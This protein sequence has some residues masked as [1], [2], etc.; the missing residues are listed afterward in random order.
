MMKADIHDVARAA[1]VSISTVSRSFTHPEMVS[2][3]TRRR[4][5][6][7]ASR[8]D[9]AISR[10][11]G[12]I[13]TGQ[14]NRVA[15]LMNESITSWFNVNVFAG[16]NRV[17]HAE[18]YDI[19]IWDHIDKAADRHEFFETLPVRRNVD[20]VFVASFATDETEVA[21]LRSIHVPLIGINTPRRRASTLPSASTTGKAWPRPHGI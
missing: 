13:K 3:Q 2:E 18:G 21:Q 4:V 19:A 20:A 11:A 6:E 5:L 12:A 8:M 1:G 16:L 7:V 17:L 10:S 15:L 9:Y 14:T